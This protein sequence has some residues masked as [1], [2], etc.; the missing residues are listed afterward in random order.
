MR[1]GPVFDD[2]TLREQLRQRLHATGISIPQ[3]KLSLR[4]S[5]PLDMLRDPATRTTVESALE[6]FATTFRAQVASPQP[7]ESPGLG[8]AL[9]LT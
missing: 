7:P 8:E 4:P 5:F 1:R 2:I 6:W 3:A 9:G